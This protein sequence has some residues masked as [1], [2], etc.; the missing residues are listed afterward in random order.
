LIVCQAAL[1][2]TANQALQAA[3]VQELAGRFIGIGQGYGS[4]DIE[5]PADEEQLAA[6]LVTTYGDIVTV[7]VGNFE[8]PLSPG[9]RP[10]QGVCDVD[11]TGPTDMGGLRATL[12]FD[13]PSFVAGDD[14]SGTVTITNTGD[15]PAS[16]SSGSPLVASIVSPGTATVVAVHTGAIAGVGDGATL[17]PGQTHTIPMVAGIASCD[18]TV[19]YAL[20]PGRYEAIVPVVVQYG[21][22][23]GEATNQLVTTAA[24]T[25]TS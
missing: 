21:Q 25:I 23:P 9:A 17:Q 6:E 22:Q 20:P 5:L 18:P 10:L 1:S 2:G 13:A 12:A 8:Y 14:I 15:Q 19:G 7:Q 3:L 11:L 16:F 4:V 24:I